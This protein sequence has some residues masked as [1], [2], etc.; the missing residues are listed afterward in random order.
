[1][2]SFHVVSV[3]VGTSMCIQCLRNEIHIR[4]GGGGGG[5]GCPIQYTVMKE[6]QLSFTIIWGL[7][8][9]LPDAL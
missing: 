2:V 6:I 1:M 8:T 5:G 4:R 7:Q 3:S 9:Q